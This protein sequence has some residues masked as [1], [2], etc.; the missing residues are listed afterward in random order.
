[1]DMFLSLNSENSNEA[2]KL[3]LLNFVQGEIT[4]EKEKKCESKEKTYI[5]ADGNASSHA[6]DTYEKVCFFYPNQLKFQ[7]Y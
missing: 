5:F 7:K 6:A 2:F 1:M 4:N 3:K